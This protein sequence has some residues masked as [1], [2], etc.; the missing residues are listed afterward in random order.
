MAYQTVFTD[1]NPDS[2][3]L[4]IQTLAETF[5][6][7]DSRLISAYGLK[8]MFT[9]TTTF[10]YGRRR[11]FRATSCSTANDLEI[12]GHFG[13]QSP[14]IK[15]WL[16]KPVPFVVKKFVE[17]NKNRPTKWLLK[18]G[19]WVVQ[20]PFRRGGWVRLVISAPSAAVALVVGVSIFKSR[21]YF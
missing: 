13:L 21:Y 11:S 12:A 17:S 19:V 3:V 7:S 9:Q 6:I 2:Y 8:L 18:I 4:F 16:L 1:V 14:P 15:R 5:T 20:Y 10:S